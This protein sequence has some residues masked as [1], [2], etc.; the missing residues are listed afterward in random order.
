MRVS[1]IGGGN[2]ANAII[3]GLKAAGVATNDMV[4]S[5]SVCLEEEHLNQTLLR[6]I[7]LIILLI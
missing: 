3:G 7:S 4:N 2:M 5:V 6:S 1:F